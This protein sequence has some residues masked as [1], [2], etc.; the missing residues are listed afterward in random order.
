LNYLG[1]A[2]LSFDQPDILAGNMIGDYVKGLAVLDTFPEGVRKGILLHRKIDMY[3]DSH[4]A[5]LRAR[6]LFRPDYRLYSGAFVDMLYDH[7]LANDPHYFSDHD[8]LKTFTTSVYNTLDGYME[9]LPARFLKMLEYMR[10][11]DWLYSYRTMK[12]MELS[13]KRLVHRARYLESSER[14]YHIFVAH[15]YELNQWY[16]ELMD[17]IV[18]FVKNELSI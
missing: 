18:K 5:G 8:T 9:I 4:P 11:E 10:A 14:A 15:Y 6:N 13:F 2:L 16:F 1:H 12:G 3:A 7:F 17:D